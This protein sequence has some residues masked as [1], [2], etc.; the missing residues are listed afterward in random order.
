MFVDTSVIVAILAKEADAQEFIDRIRSVD[1]CV[2]SALVVLEAAMR[3][4]T[5]LVLDPRDARSAILGIL[6]ELEVGIM[7]VGEAEAFA[8]IEAFALYGKGR[9]PARLNLAD[10]MSYAS[11]KV[12]DLPLLYKGRDFAQTDLA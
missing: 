12:H 4:S 1:S 6:R 5:L 9:H 11:A 3:L 8:S 7:P 2:T 10:C